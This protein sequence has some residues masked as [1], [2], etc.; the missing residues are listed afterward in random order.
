MDTSRWSEVGGG[1]VPPSP[2]FESKSYT[3]V[4]MLNLQKLF[5]FESV[6]NFLKYDGLEIFKVHHSK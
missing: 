1:G 3:I 6:R 4:K 2:T 5:E